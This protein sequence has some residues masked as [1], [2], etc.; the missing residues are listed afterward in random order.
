MQY[1]RLIVLTG[2]CLIVILFF[3]GIFSVM[4]D[5]GN[6][7][8]TLKESKS[9]SYRSTIQS[10]NRTHSNPV[11]SN[12]TDISPQKLQPG[13]ITGMNS[14]IVLQPIYPGGDGYFCN[15]SHNGDSIPLNRCTGIPTYN[16]T[17]PGSY[18]VGADN[19]NN[20]CSIIIHA[21]SVSLD[22]N[23]QTTS[24]ILISSGASDVMVNNFTEITGDGVKTYGDNSSIANNTIINV[25][26]QGI[27]VYGS[28]CILIGNTVSTVHTIIQES[29]KTA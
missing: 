1:S 8:V 25:N 28:N 14:S 7:S 3:G 23:G 18:K 11:G 13:K 19:G 15:C 12:I 16:I 21:P 20:N 27:S 17:S 6:N 24:G 2:L 5:T 10:L 22:G 26:N 4:A 29:N 9:V